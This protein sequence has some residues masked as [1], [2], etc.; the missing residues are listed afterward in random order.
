AIPNASYSATYR[1]EFKLFG[2]PLGLIESWNLS[3]SFDHRDESQRFF[4]S[5]FDT[6]Y[7]YAVRRD[8]ESVQVG[9]ISGLSYRLSP[10]HSVH[11]R[12]LYT[13]S[14]DDEVRTYQGP[15]HNRTEATTGDWLHHRGTRL[16]YVQ[17]NVLSGTFEGQHELS[18]LLGT[19][20][21]WKLSRSRSRRLQPDR[22]ETLYD[23]HYYD[24]GDGGPPVGY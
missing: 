17:R 24:L 5:A 20:L 18:R 10:R 2:R 9:G 19:S 14:A 15:D 7:D 8:K 6:L 23:L 1:D 12:G 11:L 3:R 21:N 4:Q 13:N 22:R 16:M